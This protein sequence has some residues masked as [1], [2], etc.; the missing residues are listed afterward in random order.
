VARD[1][2]VT[3]VRTD[4]SAYGAHSI[5]FDE[6][7]AYLASEAVSNDE[8]VGHNPFWLT[9]RGD[10]VVAIDAQFLP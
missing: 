7:P 2:E 6:L 4:E 3:V 5:P 1:V 9:V 8:R 10:T